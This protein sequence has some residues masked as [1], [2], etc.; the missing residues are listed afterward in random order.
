[1]ATSVLQ[2]LKAALLQRG[3]AAFMA[4]S[5]GVGIIVG[6]AAALLVWLTQLLRDVSEA[7]MDDRSWLVIVIVPVGLV[8]AWMIAGIAGREIES[9]GVTETMV[10]LSLHGGYLPSRTVFGKI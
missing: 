7:G 10:G 2:K 6:L 1:M 8:I 9:G 5:L 4:A 3:A